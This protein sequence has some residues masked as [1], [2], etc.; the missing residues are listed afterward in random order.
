MEESEASQSNEHVSCTHTKLFPNS[1]MKIAHWMQKCI[2]IH[3]VIEAAIS[4]LFWLHHSPR[5]H[6][7]DLPTILTLPLLFIPLKPLH[8]LLNLRPQIG[9]METRLVHYLA[10]IL[11]I[12]P[13]RVHTVRRP[14]LLKHN[15]YGVGE[16]DGVVRGIGREEKHLAFPDRDV[17]VLGLVD[18]FEEHG[19]AVLVEPFGGRVDVVVCA[20]VGAADDLWGGRVRGTR[21]LWKGG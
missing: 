18:H 6:I 12:P 17:A 4:S 2:I 5:H 15:A 21:G 11:A 13:Q 7:H 10:T 16:A 8:R 1:S 9:A 14:R 20:G 3:S 19:A